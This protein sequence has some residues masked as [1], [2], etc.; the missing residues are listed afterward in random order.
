MCSVLALNAGW[1]ASNREALCLIGQSMDEVLPGWSIAY[2]SESDCRAYHLS[3]ED[4][5]RLKPHPG[6]WHI[7]ILERP[8][9]LCA[10]CDSEDSFDANGAMD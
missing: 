6:A 8:R 3:L 1:K 7:E 2:I 9:I 5:S 10:D 4:V